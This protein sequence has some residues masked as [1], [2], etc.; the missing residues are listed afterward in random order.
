MRVLMSL[1]FLAVPL[2]SELPHA[3]PRDGATKVFENE[4]VIIWDVTW[5]KGKPSPMHRHK[6]DLVGAYLVGSPI[7]VTMPDGTSRESKVDEGFVLFQPKGVTHIEEGLVEENPRHAILIDL[8]D[9]D[10]API[11]NSSG[12]PSAFPR[13]GAEKRLEND[14]VII[15]DVRW[16]S[17]P[18]PMHFHDKDVVVVVLEGGEIESTTPDGQS[19]VFRVVRGEASFAP[20][21]RTHM[22]RLVSGTPRVIQVELK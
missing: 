16:T 12:L 9:H 22:E 1:L 2:Q 11:P 6:Y 13:D 15:W 18:T 3:F 17:A 20:G 14:R 19:E 10:R 8:K 21:N 7:R 4:R 5:I